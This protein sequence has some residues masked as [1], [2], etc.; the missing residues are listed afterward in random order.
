MNSIPAR[1]AARL[2]PPLPLAM[3]TWGTVHSAFERVVNLSFRLPEG[4][5]LLALCAPE[6]PKVPDS[7]VVPARLLPLLRE[8]MPVVLSP[9]VLEIHG[10]T[11]P[12]ARDALWDG[13]IARHAG[14]PSV[15]AF[16]QAAQALPAPAPSLS[17]A[18][19]ARAEAALLAGDAQRWLGLGP[20]LTPAFDD[21]CVGAMAVCR[22]GGWPV[23]FTL[24]DLSVTTDVS[25]RYLRLAQEGFFG[26]PLGDAVEALFSGVDIVGSLRRLAAVGAT[27]GHDMLRGMMLLLQKRIQKCAN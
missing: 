14:R 4:E 25:A 11:L 17:A 18:H 22:A 1:C 5:R 8:G 13:R 3:A 6:L 9:H 15:A 27:S 7:I 10:E 19:W 23:P 21:A 24:C 16:C 26:Q 12:L 20:G 2:T